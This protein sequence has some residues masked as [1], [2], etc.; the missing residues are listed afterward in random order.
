MPVLS[1]E[2][3]NC[4]LALHSR[5]LLRSFVCYRPRMLWLKWV[6]ILFAVVAVG[7]NASYGLWL[8]IG[9]KG[10]KDTLLF[11]LRGIMKLDRIANICY[12]LLL[13]TGIGLA[14]MQGV[15]LNTLWLIL[16]IGILIVM[17]AVTGMVYTPTLRK[18]IAALQ[19][20]GL[21]S[22][23]YKRI[24]AKAM[25]VGIALTVG[26]ISISWLMVFKVT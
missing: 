11:G 9:E 7:Y 10:G 14:Q 23:E 8:A 16:A 25:V 26:A 6:H 2:A 21:Q 22:P 5:L 20:H 17:G 19:S 18:Q 3:R 24:A 1:A 4:L 12:A 13:L 15:P